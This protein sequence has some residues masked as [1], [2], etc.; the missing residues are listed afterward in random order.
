MRRAER[1]FQIVQLLRSRNATTAARLGEE[2]EVS[3]RTIY[4]DIADLAS[5]DI[6]SLTVSWSVAAI[7]RNAPSRSP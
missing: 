1:L 7:A 4:R 3:E 2:L 5:S 6:A